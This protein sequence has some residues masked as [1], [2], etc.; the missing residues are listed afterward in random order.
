MGLAAGL[1]ATEHHGGHP[2]HLSESLGDVLHKTHGQVQFALPVGPVPMRIHAY[3]IVL[4]PG[5]SQTTLLAGRRLPAAL[6][7]RIRFPGPTIT[8]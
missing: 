4:K 2:R 1:R 7:P 3:L 5:S 6:A 8:I